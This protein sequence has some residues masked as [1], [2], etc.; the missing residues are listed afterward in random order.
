[1]DDT[2]ITDLMIDRSI[3]GP[4]KFAVDTFNETLL[5]DAE[6]RLGL[7]NWRATLDLSHSRNA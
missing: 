4:T 7:G 5:A 3:A 2:V 1:M 6:L